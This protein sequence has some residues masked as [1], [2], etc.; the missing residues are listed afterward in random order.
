MQERI[1]KIIARAGICSRRKAED[2]IV[3]GLVSVNGRVVRELGAKADPAHDEVR[4]QGK[5]ILP[6]TEALYIMLHR[7]A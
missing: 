6:E 5:R 1:Q 7:P 4:V 3:Q 2:L